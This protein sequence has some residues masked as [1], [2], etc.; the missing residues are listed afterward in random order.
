MSNGA[1]DTMVGIIPVVITGGI[2]LK[3]TEAIAPRRDQLFGRKAKKKKN[4]YSRG[5]SGNFSNVGF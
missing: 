4:V 2:L 1:V 5:F 3:F